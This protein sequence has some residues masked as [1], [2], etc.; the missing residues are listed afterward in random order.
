MK[1]NKIFCLAALL[2]LIGDLFA[3]Q[4]AT[5]VPSGK[6]AVSGTITD[7]E[8][9]EDLVGA[10]IYV[11]SLGTGTVTNVYGFYSL[12]L[13]RGKYVLVANYIGYLVNMVEVE[14]SDNTT[15]NF[16][17][18]SANTELGQV[19][20][21]ADKNNRNLIAPDMGMEKL[22]IKTIKSIPTLFGEADVIKSIQFLPGVGS[23]GEGFIGYNVRGGGTGQNLMLLDEATVYNAAHLGGFFSVFNNDALKDVKFYKGG[24]PAE[25]GGRLS[26]LLDVRMKEGGN[27]KY[28]V[29]GGIGLLSSRLTIDGPIV[30]DKCSFILSGRRSY[31]D[32]FFPFVDDMPDK[33][34]MYFYDLNAKVNYKINDKN[35]VFASGYFGR[36][37]M[38]FADLYLMEYGNKTLTTRYNHVFGERLFSNLS[39]IYSDFDYLLGADKDKWASSIRDI[40]GK[41]D[42]TFFLNPSN[43]VKYGANFTAHNFTPYD[44]VTALGNVSMEENDHVKTVDYAGYLSNETKFGSKLMIDYGLR[45]SVMHNL[46]KAKELVMDSEYNVIDTIKH[47]KGIFNTYHG[48]EPR[49][50]VNYMVD[51]KRSIKANFQQ[52]YQYIHLASNTMSPLPIDTWFAST[53]NVKPE[54]CRMVSVGY[55]RNFASD[56]YATSVEAYYKKIYNATD[57]KDHAMLLFNTNIEDQIRLGSGYSY[58]VEFMLKKQ[59]G[60]FTGWLSY[61]YSRTF[62]KIDGINNGDYYP[63]N[64]DKPH[65]FSVVAMYDVTPR[66]NLSL[67]WVYSTGVPRTLP[68][69]RFEY[70][71]VVA[72][73]YTERNAMRLPD[74]HRLD[75]SATFK[76]K[77]VVRKG[78]T[79]ME[80]DL[81]V[82]VY[83]LYNRHNTS[84]VIFTQ[85]EDD[86]SV[87][88]AEKLYLFGM[89]PSI[90]YNF[91]F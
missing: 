25:Y 54:K 78:K 31:M 26:S 77:D 89:F 27:Q 15:L 41:A 13:P 4:M 11:K 73:V 12:T 75:F 7:A 24:I 49:L 84:S 8:T 68:T 23:S 67:N 83:N 21:V 53:P 86:P 62:A 79:F 88:T 22:Q 55:F 3:Q 40:S 65:D 17:M 76:L 16:K 29:N 6:C 34:T 56:I 35:R 71:D 20:V 80:H 69:G 87:V 48:F 39:F 66:I 2:L 14:L 63:S 19:D 82:S 59:E 58:G 43:T 52:T 91:K 46:G 51:S 38:V 85:D 5:I 57:F 90:T 9:G 1:R 28:S 45:F 42:F 33:T 18:K 50:S 74:F 32:L 60:S 37:V 70:G 10:T 61:T 47:G 44:Y 72:P 30:K 36:D 64:Y 81:N